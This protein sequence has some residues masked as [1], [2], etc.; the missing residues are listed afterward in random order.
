MANMWTCTKHECKKFSKERRPT[1]Q[2][3][4]SKLSIVLGKLSIVLWK[5]SIVF[6][7]Y[8]YFPGGQT[9]ALK[10]SIF[11]KCCF[12]TIDS[13]DET[14]DSFSKTIDTFNVAKPRLPNYRYFQNLLK[15][16]R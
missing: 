13:F 14:I 5:L 7:N 15:N 10:L 8:R 11:S 2:N 4:Y 3:F 9:Q 16:Y 12:E 1:A 6:P